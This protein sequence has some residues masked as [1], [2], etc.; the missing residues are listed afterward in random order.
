MQDAIQGRCDLGG[1][2]RAL[3]F[4][5]NDAATIDDEHPGLRV[6]AP[7]NDSRGV[8]VLRI[9]LLVDLD[10]NEVHTPAVLLLQALHLFDLWPAE[11]AG[12]VRSGGKEQKQRFVL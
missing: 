2:S 3:E 11:P 7:L 4:V 9:G 1:G 8:S 12:A 5:P 10:V 6:Q